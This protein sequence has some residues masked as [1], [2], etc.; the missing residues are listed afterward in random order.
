[1]K[2]SIRLHEWMS[3][4]DAAQ[5]ANVTPRTISRWI[6]HGARYIRI[7]GKRHIHIDALIDNARAPLDDLTRMS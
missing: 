7:G 1:M 4:P 2:A 3:I 6:E 5:A